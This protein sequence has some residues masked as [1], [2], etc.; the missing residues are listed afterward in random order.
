ME[1]AFGDSVTVLDADNAPYTDEAAPVFEQFVTTQNANVLVDT[2]GYGDI[3]TEVCDKHPDIYCIQTA[4]FTKLGKNTTGWFPKLWII[5][6]TA[7]VAAGLSTKSEHGRLRARL[8]AAADH[9]RGERVHD[10]LSSA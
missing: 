1:D 6:Y 7:G 5:E 10:G 4:P 9:R 2:A 8:R 3:F